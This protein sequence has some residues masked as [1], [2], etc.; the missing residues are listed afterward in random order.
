MRKNLNEDSDLLALL[1]EDIDEAFGSSE[2]LLYGRW[3]DIK[4]QY[5]LRPNL[6]PRLDK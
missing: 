2:E 6:N 4:T 5:A 1:I 3:L